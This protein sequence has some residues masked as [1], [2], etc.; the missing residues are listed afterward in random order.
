M[1]KSEGSIGSENSEAVGGCILSEKSILIEDRGVDG[2]K[3]R[4]FFQLLLTLAEIGFRAVNE[5][6]TA[7]SSD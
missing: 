3:G 1:N 6:A 7:F 5:A 4:G 2:G